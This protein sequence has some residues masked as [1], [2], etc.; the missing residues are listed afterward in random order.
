MHLIIPEVEHYVSTIQSAGQQQYIG[1]V[2]NSPSLRFA[3]NI[4]SQRKE[5][6][7]KKDGFETVNLL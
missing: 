3:S 6:V 2:D 1:I 5:K 4:L 7:R